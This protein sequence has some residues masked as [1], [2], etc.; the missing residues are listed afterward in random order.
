MGYCYEKA[1]PHSEFMEWDSTDRS[2]VLAWRIEE[3]MKCGMCGTAEW[4]WEQ[5]KFAYHP[6]NKMC[7]GCYLKDIASET[8][9]N[10]PGTTVVLVP[11]DAVTDEMLRGGRQ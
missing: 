5:D 2:K 10:V 8:E 9:Q 3:G 6:V 1:I 11:K 4:E 7:R